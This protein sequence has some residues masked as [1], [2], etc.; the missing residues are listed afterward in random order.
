MKIRIIHFPRIFI[1]R[2]IRLSFQLCQVLTLGRLS[3]L[4]CGTVASPQFDV[5]LSITVSTSIPSCW[6]NIA[7]L[8]PRNGP[9]FVQNSKVGCVPADS[10]ALI[11]GSSPGN[12]HPYRKQD[13][14]IPR[15][16]F[17]AIYV[18]PLSLPQVADRSTW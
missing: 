14:R 6:R 17:P 5:D 18:T 12:L 3:G 9:F 13:I 16:Y 1:P 8:R 15:I 11:P 2:T 10:R 7:S 4:S